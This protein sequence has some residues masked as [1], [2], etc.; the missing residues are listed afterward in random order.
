MKIYQNGSRGHTVRIFSFD[1][2]WWFNVQLIGTHT[3]LTVDIRSSH[4]ITTA[5]QET[6][7]AAR[8]G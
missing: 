7:T 2:V 3:V 1:T 4:H 8:D 6:Q 5:R